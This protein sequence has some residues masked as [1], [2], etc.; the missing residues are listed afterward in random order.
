MTTPTIEELAS[1]E[2]KAGFLTDIEAE[3]VPPGLNEDIVRVISL[4]TCS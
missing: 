2:Y 1:R 3:T 4:S